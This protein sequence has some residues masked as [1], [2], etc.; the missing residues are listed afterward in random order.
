MPPGDVTLPRR[1]RRGIGA[2]G[3]LPMLVCL[4][5]MIGC[6]PRDDRQP[7]SGTISWQGKPLAKGVITLYPKGPGSTVGCDI[8]DGKFSI[9]LHKGATPGAYRVQ[10][11]AFRPTGKTEFDIERNARV[12]VE[13]QYL[14]S[15]F[16]TA[17]KLE[18]EIKS[19]VK[20]ELAFDLEPEK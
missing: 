1:A 20:N 11:V 13:E 19:G 12:D 9:D 7:V 18:A 15:R 16:N 14:P 17:S 2:L 3:W 10:V 6:G 5:A 4:A 8:F